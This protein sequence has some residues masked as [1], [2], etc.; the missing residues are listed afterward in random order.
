MKSRKSL[1]VTENNGVQASFYNVGIAS[2][3]V[4]LLY[5]TGSGSSSATIEKSNSVTGIVYS[6]GSSLTGKSLDTG[7]LTFGDSIATV[8]SVKKAAIVKVYSGQGTYGS[9]NNA[10]NISGYRKSYP[11]S[12][13]II[14]SEYPNVSTSN[15]FGLGISEESAGSCEK[16]SY[17]EGMWFNK[18][19]S[20]N[21]FLMGFGISVAGDLIPIKLSITSSAYLSLTTSCSTSIWVQQI[22]E[23]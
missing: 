15:G 19:G 22:F 11:G 8:N 14:R 3:G 18:N 6:N 1:S 23:T 12:K 13:I 21:S 17:F 5:S 2:S 7:N 4:Y 10:V 16:L 20:S 9:G